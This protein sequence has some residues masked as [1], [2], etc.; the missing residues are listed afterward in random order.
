[1]HALCDFPRISEQVH[2]N[3]I[4]GRL[5]VDMIMSASWSHEE[6]PPQPSADIPAPTSHAR[7]PAR[8]SA[9][10]E[11]IHSVLN[12]FMHASLRRLILHDFIL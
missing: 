10:L 1:M 6:S 5:K 7:P 3:F 12:S 11:S 9:R 2:E 8:S 4:V